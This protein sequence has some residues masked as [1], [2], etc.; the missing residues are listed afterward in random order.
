M[1]DSRVTQVLLMILALIG[2]IAFVALLVAVELGWHSGAVPP[3]LLAIGI[4]LLRGHDLRGHQARHRPG[5]EEHSALSGPWS[6]QDGEPS[7]HENRL[8][9]RISPQP[10]HHR[11]AGQVEQDG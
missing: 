5:D 1:S 6:G 2:P 8:E 9:A 11:V 10:I 3:V 4:A 7:L